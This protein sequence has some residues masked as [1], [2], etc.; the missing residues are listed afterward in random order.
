MD[1]EFRMEMNTGNGGYGFTDT[2]SELLED[3]E[4][5]YD[6]NEVKKVSEWAKT[7][8]DGDE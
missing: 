7:S 3:V 1:N 6:N 4:K 8:K 5:E 2:L